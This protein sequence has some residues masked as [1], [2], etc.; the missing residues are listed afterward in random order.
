MNFT[1]DVSKWPNTTLSQ[2]LRRLYQLSK[3][4]VKINRTMTRMLLQKEELSPED[5]EEGV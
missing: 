5:I 3:E 4:Y 2:R 1:T